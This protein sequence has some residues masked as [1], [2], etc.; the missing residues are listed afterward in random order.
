MRYEYTNAMGETRYIES[1]MK[2]P[3]PER[4][5]FCDDGTWDAA[6][7][8]A[9]HGVWVRVYGDVQIQDSN[10]WSEKGYGKGRVDVPKG[11]PGCEV[12][13]QGRTIIRDKAH[14]REICRRYGYYRHED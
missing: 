1:S 14:E 8:G 10:R 11:L 4:V 7:E 13:H 12:D 6:P 9:E 2:A 3:P 5:M